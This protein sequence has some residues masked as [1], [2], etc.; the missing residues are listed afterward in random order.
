MR[1]LLFLLLIVITSAYPCLAQNLRLP[2]FGDPSQRYLSDGKERRL[3]TS[4]FKRLRERDLLLDD[5]QLNEYLSSVGQRIAANADGGHPYSFYWLK[6]GSVNAFAVPGGFIGVHSGLVLATRDEAELAGVVAHEI[7]HVSQ[8]HI[9]RA[10][11][12]TQ[13]FNVATA[14]AV[15][16]SI[17]IASANSEAGQAALA[18]TLAAGAQRRLNMSRAN[19]QEA[20]R[21]GYQLLSRS[22]YD[23]DGMTRFF[24]FLQR[25]SGDSIA[26]IPEFLLTHPRASSRVSDTQL[27]RDSTISQRPAPS[28]MGYHLA[29]ARALVLTSTNATTLIQHFKNTLAKGA[30]A[31][32]QAERYGYVLA[33]KQAGRYAEAQGQIQRLLQADPDKLAYRIEQAEIALAAGDANTAWRLFANAAQLYPDDYT[34]AVHH[35]RALATQGNPKLA[36]QLLEPYLQRRARDLALYEVYA[37]AAQRAGDRAATHAALA[38]FYYLGGDLK[39]AIEQAELGLKRGRTTPY[40]QA[41]LQARLRQFQSEKKTQE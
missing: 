8:R 40:E 10:Y 5:V 18:G 1:L 30:Y 2:D 27:R 34:L 12:D 41:R 25:S 23:P 31:N 32:E 38:E 35:G 37:Q 6:A 39:G 19:E 3:G 9:A 33:L 20:D 14:A 7:A 22:S 21:I 15:L 24:D 29:K 16:A 17:A 36:M 26:H 13:Q 11:A 28:S 4:I